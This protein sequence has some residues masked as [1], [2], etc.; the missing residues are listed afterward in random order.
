M[1][2]WTDGGEVQMDDEL[3]GLRAGGRE[4]ERQ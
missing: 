4:R 2:K 3:N 1:C